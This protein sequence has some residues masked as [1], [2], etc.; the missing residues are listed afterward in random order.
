MEDP[1]LLQSNRM[2]NH[3]VFPLKTIILQALKILNYDY[4][5]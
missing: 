1:H 5:V 4:E 3:A 2:S